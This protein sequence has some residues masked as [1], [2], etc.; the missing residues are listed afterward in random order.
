MNRYHA[1]FGTGLLSSISVLHTAN[2]R[3]TPAI[4]VDNNGMITL[5]IVQS[6]ISLYMA[7]LETNLTVWCN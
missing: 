6:M 4:Y 3:Q 7:H 2:A 5:Y 1:P